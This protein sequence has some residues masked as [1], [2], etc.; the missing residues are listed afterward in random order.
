M[1]LL[2]DSLNHDAYACHKAEGEYAMKGAVLDALSWGKGVRC[3][4]VQPPT[5][6]MAMDVALQKGS[7]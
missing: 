1:K 4:V 7:P 6:P 2:N 5:E 3:S